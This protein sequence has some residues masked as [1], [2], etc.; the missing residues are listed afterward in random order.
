MCMIPLWGSCLRRTS[1]CRNRFPAT[2][3]KCLTR[4]YASLSHSLHE[5]INRCWNAVWVI[6]PREFETLRFFRKTMLLQMHGRC[7]M[8]HEI[9]SLRSLVWPQFFEGKLVNFSMGAWI[10]LL[11]LNMSFACFASTHSL[12]LLYDVY[13]A[14]LRI[15]SLLFNCSLS[16]FNVLWCCRHRTN[17]NLL[18]CVF[19]WLLNLLGCSVFISCRRGRF[20]VFIV[21]TW[22]DMV[23]RF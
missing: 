10:P 23:W 13:L 19:N 20:Q 2:A 5:L 1:T 18:T 15:I 12:K 7:G 8:F 6:A 11:L 17:Q 9:V 14:V 16:S 21:N 22:Y 4:R 3:S